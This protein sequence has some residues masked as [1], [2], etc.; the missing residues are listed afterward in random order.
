MIN[1]HEPADSEFRLNRKW[2]PPSATGR[3]SNHEDHVCWIIANA[4][5]VL[6]KGVLK[7]ISAC[8][9]EVS[10][11]KWTQRVQS[12]LAAEAT[13]ARKLQEAFIDLVSH[14]MRNP[15]SAITQLADDIASS[16][17][18]WV[19]SDRMSERAA[20]LLNENVESGKTILL[21]AAH[22]KRIIDDVLT[23]SK[24]DS[25]LLSISPVVIQ[26]R[27][28][29][30]SALRMFQAE[31]TSSGITIEN[32]I[33]QAYDTYGI[34]WV[35]LDPARLTQI[36]INLITNA[37]KFT[38]R[39]SRRLITIRQS[40][41]INDRPSLDGLVWFPSDKETQDIT[42][43]PE[44]GNGEQVNL[45]FSVSDTGKG[46]QQEE[47]MRLFHRFQQA[48]KKTHIKYG[49]SGLG[50]FISRELTETMGGEVG[51]ISEPGK[52][53]TF[54][55][56]VKARRA[57][58]PDDHD[59]VPRPS[60]SRGSS[61]RASEPLDKINW[62]S[63]QLSNTTIT[64]PRLSV[65]LVE[66]N[67]I[68]AQVL[69]KQLERAG[70]V[71]YIANHGLEAL[72]FLTNCKVWHQ[73]AEDSPLIELDCILMDVEMPVLDGLSC[74]RRIRAL[75]GQGSLLQRLSIIA[76]TANARAEQIEDAFAAGVDG[77]LPKPFRVLDV[78]SKMEELKPR[79]SAPS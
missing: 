72:D 38:K 29:V 32:T 55:F 50:L 13:K 43:T 42:N 20:R 17:D 35:L 64:P 52:G 76:I 5:P 31:F 73:P 56:Y 61:R 3:A 54:A 62:I 66:D 46:L 51:V 75:E 71:V 4:F 59:Q 24:L 18:N 14:E 63:R 25:Q 30:E 6:E 41:F 33:E 1:E 44:W 39:E 36:L 70:C 21:C 26:P 12:Q 9:T 58:P 67:I 78:L 48:T 8:V 19:V 10:E 7:S 22:Q 68:N 27:G 57:V 47:M 37:I 60:Q 69:M 79:R 53:S 11:I 16:L 34:D 65:L 28:V 23:L 15:L 74:T 77:I 2:E 40:V 45:L 49:G